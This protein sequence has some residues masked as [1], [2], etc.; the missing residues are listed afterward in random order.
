[1]SDLAQQSKSQVKPQEHGEEYFE[2]FSIPAFDAGRKPVVE[3]GTAIKSNKFIVVD[4]CVLLSKLNPR[5]PRIWLPPKSVE[6]RQIASTEFLVLM[7]RA[8]FDHHYLYCQ[9]QQSQFRE[10]LAQGASG[11]S[12]SHQRVRPD[13]LLSKRVVIPL[14]NCCDGFRSTVNPLFAQLASQHAESEKL[15]ELRD[16][17]LP[18]LLA[19]EVRVARDARDEVVSE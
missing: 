4:E 16:Y 2:H 11:T 3:L 1:M 12:N 15:G 18:K 8:G 5:I 19:G 13:D 7:P 10:D 17:L 6:R 14:S 9:F